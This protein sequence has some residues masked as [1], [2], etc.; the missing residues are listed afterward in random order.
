MFKLGDIVV[1]GMWFGDSMILITSI[2]TWGYRAMFINGMFDGVD[3]KITHAYWYDKIGN[4]F[5][6]KEKGE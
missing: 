5:D 4:I 6:K 2:E 3:M 1:N